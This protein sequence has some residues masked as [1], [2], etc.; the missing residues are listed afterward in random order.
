MQSPRLASVFSSLLAVCCALSGI[1]AL[2]STGIAITATNVTMPSSGNGTSAYT[3]TGIPG[4]GTVSI[5][6]LYS[7]TISEA[8]IPNCTYGPLDSIPVTAGQTLT[9]TV[10]FYP[11]GAAVPVKLHKAPRPNV[12]PAGGLALAGALMVGFG[13]RRKA[14]HWLAVA[15]LA[16]GTLAG[17]SG[18]SGCGGLSKSMTPGTYQ[19]TIVATYQDTGAPILGAILNANVE[20]TV[21]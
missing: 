8:R 10:Q 12:L 13:M 19:Y 20:V 16:M 17:M 2:A 7:G 6:C 3:I 14:W 11:F 9:G 15:A 18:I 21:E 1:R 4:A 5:G